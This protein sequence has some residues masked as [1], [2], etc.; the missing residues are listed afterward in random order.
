MTS[1]E[2]LS[3]LLEARDLYTNGHS[4]R[5]SNIASK[6]YEEM[7]GVNEHFLDVLWAAKLHLGGQRA[8]PS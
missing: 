7:Y 5:V 3:N 1:M 8:S 6:L 2:M 4:K